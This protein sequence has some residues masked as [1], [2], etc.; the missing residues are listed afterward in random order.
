MTLLRIA[1]LF[2]L[3]AVGLLAQAPVNVEEGPPPRAVQFILGYSGSN[4]IYLCQSP[5]AISTGQRLAVNVPISA[6]SKASP[7]VV[8]SVG[9]GFNLNSRPSVS[10]SGATGTGWVSGANTVNGTFVA[11][12]IDADT[13]SIPVNTTG[14]GTLAGTV[15]FVTTAP[16]INVPEWAVQKLVYDGSNNLIWKGWLNGSSSYQAKCSDATSTSNQQ[17]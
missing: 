2:P 4:L 3:M 6:I 17:Q 12:I 11:T 15:V 8:T 9:H 16:R 7:A 1:V 13:F 14:N 5:S 10:L